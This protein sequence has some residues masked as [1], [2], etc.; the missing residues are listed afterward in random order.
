MSCSLS[1]QSDLLKDNS[2]HVESSSIEENAPDIIEEASQSDAIEEPLL[3]DESE[4]NS[5]VEI[6]PMVESPIIEV[7]TIDDVSIG[8]D[9][10]TSP[11]RKRRTRAEMD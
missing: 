3:I 6:V 4:S 2:V 11:R 10:I 8:S 7:P 1:L 9:N 5:I